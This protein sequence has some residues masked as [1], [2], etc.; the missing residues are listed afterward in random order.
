MRERISEQLKNKIIDPNKEIEK[1]S[2]DV[3]Y[4]REEIDSKKNKI[5]NKSKKFL[6]F[7]P[8]KSNFTTQL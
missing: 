8:K 4:K 5:K 3:G 1:V 7:F 6:N 2:L